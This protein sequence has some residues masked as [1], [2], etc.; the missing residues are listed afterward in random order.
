MPSSA[1]V[2]YLV[3][4]INVMHF[5]TAMTVREYVKS[6]MKNKEEYGV[7]GYH[8]PKTNALD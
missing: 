4:E 7:T 5:G 8:I 6:S 2:S 1:Q 3:Q